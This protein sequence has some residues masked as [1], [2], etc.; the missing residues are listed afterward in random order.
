MCRVVCKSES[1]LK[2]YQVS[3]YFFHRGSV[4]GCQYDQNSN[5]TVSSSIFEMTGPVKLDRYFTPSLLQTSSVAFHDSDDDM[6]T[7]AIETKR[8]IKHHIITP[9]AYKP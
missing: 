7:G 2:S 6:Y 1:R 9:Q 8:L 4:V 3:C 5:F